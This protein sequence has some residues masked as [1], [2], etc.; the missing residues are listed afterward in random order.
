MQG[1]MNTAGH[2]LEKLGL[3]AES[4][5]VSEEEKQAKREKRRL[6]RQRQKERKAAGPSQLL[7]VLNSIIRKSQSLQTETGSGKGA[8]GEKQN[9]GAP[10]KFVK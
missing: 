3:V 5:P 7:D 1:C 6:K 4:R 8:E 9:R 2:L 10:P